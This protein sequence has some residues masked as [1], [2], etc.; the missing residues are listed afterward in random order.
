MS[1]FTDQPCL[2]IYTAN[3]V[4]D[5]ATPFKNAVRPLP[6]HVVCLEA[7]AMP[8]ALHHPQIANILLYPGQRYE[9][10]IV[11]TFEREEAFS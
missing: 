11:F 1:V 2:Q 6:H 5:H 10:N 7:Q 3:A 9:K 8:D 4:A